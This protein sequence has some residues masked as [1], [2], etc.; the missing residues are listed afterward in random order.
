MKPSESQAAK[1][2][3]SNSAL[4]KRFGT[5]HN[6]SNGSGGRTTAAAS[7]PA[8]SSNIVNNKYGESPNDYGKGVS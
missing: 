5:P 3:T 6:V 2:A 1:Q 8:V 4:Q 7:R